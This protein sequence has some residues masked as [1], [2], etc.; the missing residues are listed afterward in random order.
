MVDE[1]FGKVN[2]DT[3]WYRNDLISFCNR[4]WKIYV[5]ANSYRIT[6]LIT[7][8]QRTTYA[9][10]VENQSMIEKEIEDLLISYGGDDFLLTL[11]PTGLILQREGGYAILFDDMSDMDNGIAVEL[12]P[13]KEVMTQD[14]YL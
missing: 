3:G 6:D 8:D 14:D 13:N 1:I 10:F 7:D 9:N 2:F 12:S 4:K 11:K 5:C